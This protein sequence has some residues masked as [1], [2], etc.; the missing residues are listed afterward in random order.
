MYFLENFG[1]V[2]LKS[3]N[4]RM[5]EFLL[6]DKE[7]LLM[8]GIKLNISSQCSTKVSY[9]QILNKLLVKNTRLQKIMSVLIDDCFIFLETAEWDEQLE[10][11]PSSLYQVYISEGSNSY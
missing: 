1:M 7:S 8:L 3:D 2:R 11:T 5:K 10:H 4:F 9:F 6:K